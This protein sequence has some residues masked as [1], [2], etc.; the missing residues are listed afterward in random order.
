M[1]IK[2][3]QTL[4]GCF[5]RGCYPTEG[6]FADLIDSFMH[7]TE[8][9]LGIS[10]VAGLSASLNRKFDMRSGEELIK[11]HRKTSEAV[12]GLERRVEAMALE[13]VRFEDLDT[14][15]EESVEDF[16]ASMFATD[17][18]RAR[19]A[20]VNGSG[21]SLA[22]IG[23]LEVFR[24]GSCTVT[25]MFT[26]NCFFQDDGAIG[27]H[28]DEKVHTY[29]RFFNISSHHSSAEQ[30]CWSPWREHMPAEEISSADIERWFDEP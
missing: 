22:C 28:D 23:V 24:A 1:G 4:K 12:A 21:N 16:V 2:K 19:H 27:G 7:K 15:G 18:F 9:Q 17:S 26:T 30:F 10:D 25:Q 20:V 11:A 13:P 6:Q 3:R 8:D 5:K 14:M 29:V